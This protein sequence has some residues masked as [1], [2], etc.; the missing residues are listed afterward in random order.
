MS[1]SVEKRYTARVERR[2]WRLESLV[3]QSQLL[4]DNGGGDKMYGMT[5]TGQKAAVSS[6]PE[7]IR[8]REFWTQSHELSVAG[9]LRHI[10]IPSIVS[11][12]R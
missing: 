8:L 12:L 11:P 1:R 5:R 6:S 4:P 9:Q 10:I 3:A 7:K 2:R